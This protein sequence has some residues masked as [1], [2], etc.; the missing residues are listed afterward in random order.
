VL[1]E[2]REGRRRGAT[3]VVLAGRWPSRMTMAWVEESGTARLITAGEPRRTDEDA[4]DDAVELAAGALRALVDTAG[5]TPERLWMIGP[6]AADRSYFRGLA[7]A[8]AL[9]ELPAP[10][11]VPLPVALVGG[12]L[13]ARFG[14][15]RV[16]TSGRGGTAVVLDA[17][18][19]GITAWPVATG[20]DAPEVIGC[21]PVEVTDRVDELMTG[22]VRATL[23]L[24]AAAPAEGTAGRRDAVR[25]HRGVRQARRRLATSDV[26]DAAV[27][28]GERT[29]FVERAVFSQLVVHAV[30]ECLAELRVEAGAELLGD[31]SGPVAGVV[32]GTA[33]A[34]ITEPGGPREALLGAGVLAGATRFVGA[35]PAAEA[36]APPVARHAPSASPDPRRA[37]RPAP[38]A[39]P[40][41]TRPWW[42][43]PVLAAV[44]VVVL[45]GSI[46]VLVLGPSPAGWAVP[47]AAVPA[48]PAVS[49]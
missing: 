12:R 11:W 32:A 6:T 14:A 36:A 7:D 15:A 49:P 10:S 17:R 46:G 35:A 8:A 40:R 23:G 37:P 30:A 16:G 39:T 19:G 3:M 43:V 27:R 20:A 26:A 38:R 22:V 47:F 34:V 45:L 25:L 4:D 21:G 31:A 5:A 41:P 33:R 48:G 9:A 13:A 18:G 24:S 29:G 1:D 2:V 44:L 42:A 28:V